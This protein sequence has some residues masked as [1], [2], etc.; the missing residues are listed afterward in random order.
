MINKIIKNIFNRKYI[1]LWCIFLIGIIIRLILMDKVGSSDA[2]SFYLWSRFLTGNK[3]SDLYEFLPYGYLPYPPLYYFILKISGFIIQIFN[4]WNNHWISYF[5]IRFPVFLSEIVTT[6]LIFNISKKFLNVTKASVCAGFYFLHPAII[7]N[8]M[9]WGQ[10]DSVVIMLT[11]LTIILI[12]NKRIYAGLLIYTASLLIKLQS[13][14]ILPLILYLLFIFSRRLK[15]VKA[16]IIAFIFGVSL[17]LPVIINKGFLWTVKYFINLPNQYP[18]T[19]VYTYNLWSIAGFMVP[20]SNKILFIPYKYLGIGLF[21]LIAGYIIYQFK[22]AVKLNTLSLVFAGFLLF[23]DFAYFSTRMHS[24][25]LIYSLGFIAPF[26]VSEPFLC[27]SISG[28]IFI[29][30]L[31]PNHE[32]YL[33]SITSILNKPSVINLFSLTTLIFFV[34]ALQKY[35]KLNN[36]EKKH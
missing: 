22:K 25:Y 14:A 30:L 3:I 16:T 17:F 35:L 8:S 27:I 15:P 23:I 20:D 4:A 24:R 2:A 11:L 19:S 1:L 5:I 6:L 26:F 18:Y 21:W 7:Y 10:I 31:L 36:Y 12:Y 13:L 9:I 32:L 33:S 28:L 34:H 29:N